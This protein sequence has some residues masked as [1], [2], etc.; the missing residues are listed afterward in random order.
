MPAS[1][2]ELEITE[3]VLLQHTDANLETLRQLKELGVRIGMDDFGTG[4]ASLA[5]LRRFRST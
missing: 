4:Y 3:G 5:C 1:L 2:L